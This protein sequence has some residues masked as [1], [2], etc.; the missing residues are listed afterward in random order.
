MEKKKMIVLKEETERDP[1]KLVVCGVRKG[2]NGFIQCVCGI[3]EM[4]LGKKPIYKI[5]II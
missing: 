3:K 5:P 2:L 4:N 1:Q